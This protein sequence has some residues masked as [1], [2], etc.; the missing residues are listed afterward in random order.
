MRLLPFFAI[1]GLLIALFVLPPGALALA[2][3][4]Q[5]LALVIGNSRYS[6]S[7]L[8]N[9]VNDAEDIADALESTGFEV[10]L[11][12]DA[13]QRAMERAVRDF[14]RRLRSG[15][16]GLFYYAG[17]GL[18]IDGRNYLIPVDAEI[19]SES[20]VKYEAVDAGRV[21]GKMEDAGNGLNIVILDACRDNPFARSFRSGRKG[22]AKMDAP[23]G[24]LLAYATAPG[25]VAADGTGRNGLYTSKL[26]R[27]IQTPGMKIEDVFKQV[28]RA[29]MADSGRKQVPWE[30]SSMAGDFFFTPAAPKPVAAKPAPVAAP[31]HVQARIAALEA[32]NRLKMERQRLAAERQQLKAEKKLMAERQALEAEKLRLE[33]EK[34]LL[35]EQRSL[36]EEKNKVALQTAKLEALQAKM[37]ADQQQTRTAE[38]TRLAYAP[39]ANDRQIVGPGYRLALFPEHATVDSNYPWSTGGYAITKAFNMVKAAL[40]ETL[41][42]FVDRKDIRL[43]DAAIPRDKLSH[44]AWTLGDIRIVTGDLKEQ[45]LKAL[46]HR[47]S[48]FSSIEPDVDKAVAMGKAIGV[49]L[50]LM[51]RMVKKGKN[52]NITIYLIDVSRKKAY[53]KNIL[54]RSSRYLKKATEELLDSFVEKHPLSAAKSG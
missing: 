53:K 13:N 33:T 52:N 7:P 26:L 2:S 51:H 22:L 27:F 9:P 15:G 23:V 24:S 28:R 30:S 3:G 48:T 49:D 47:P 29:V 21:L 46:W 19:E 17:H 11:K 6:A 43:T 44:K 10:I 8:A 38:P 37:A 45:D 39:S 5:R 31:E 50:V 18:Q 14:G 41:N 35:A 36:N 34:K 20:D 54:I 32:E 12:T 42:V 16:V 1:T 25:S 4:D 40:D